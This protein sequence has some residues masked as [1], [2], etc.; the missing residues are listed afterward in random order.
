MLLSATI[1]NLIAYGLI[2]Y[3]GSI[4]EAIKLNYPLFHILAIYT[5]ILAISFIVP[6]IVYR[7]ISRATLIERLREVE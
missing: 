7:N 1:G 5:L 2:L 6:A 4:D 3:A